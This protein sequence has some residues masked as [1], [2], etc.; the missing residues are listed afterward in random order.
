M[1]LDKYNVA[2]SSQSIEE[3]TKEFFQYKETFAWQL[4]NILFVNSLYNRRLF[5]I[6]EY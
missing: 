3:L 4:V 5:C 2:Q 1:K 6:F